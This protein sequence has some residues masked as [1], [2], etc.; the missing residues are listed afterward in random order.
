MTAALALTG[1]DQA[2]QKTD[3]PADKP[4]EKPADKPIEI[5]AEQTPVATEQKDEK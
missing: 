2:E 4:I 5:P 1:C 3:K